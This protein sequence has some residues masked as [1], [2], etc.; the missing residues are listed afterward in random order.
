MDYVRFEPTTSAMPLQN[1]CCSNPTSVQ[2]I[3][4]DKE[5]FG[6]IN[7]IKKREE[8]TQVVVALSPLK[9]ALRNRYAPFF[10]V[11][12]CVLNHF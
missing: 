9:Y 6:F 1:I 4:L 12:K 10:E 2:R 3:A 11:L 8:Y 7:D 5:L